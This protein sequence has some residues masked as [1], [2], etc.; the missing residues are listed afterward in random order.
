MAIQY[1]ITEVEMNSLMDQIKLQTMLDRNLIIHPDRYAKLDTDAREAI[2]DMHRSFHMVA[3][4]WAQ[5]IGFKGD[6]G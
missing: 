1:V 4:R 6:R 2:A 5:S 3:V